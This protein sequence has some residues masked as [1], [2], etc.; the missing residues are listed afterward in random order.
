MHLIRHVLILLFCLATPAFADLKVVVSIKPIHSLVGA[1]MQNAGTPELLLDGTASPHDYA[2]RPS[3]ARRLQ[4]A[5]LVF[6]LGPELETFLTKPLKTLSAEKAH[7][8]LDTPDLVKLPLRDIEEAHDHAHA[9][10]GEHDPHVWLSPANA[11]ILTR[12]IAKI[13]SERDPAHATVYASNANK[14]MADLSLLDNELKQSLALLPKTSVVVFHDAYQYFEQAYG[15]TPATPLSM[16]PESPPGAKRLKALRQDLQCGKIKCIF[17]EPQFPTRLIETLTEGLSIKLE[18][19]DPLGANIN[20]GPDHYPQML[21]ALAASWK[22][23][24]S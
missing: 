4:N 9:E 8:L 24:T 23:C 19:L 18:T 3:D 13:L 10:H 15:L 7:A 5:D 17:S 22:R 6:W 21:R 12:A 16:N 11:S 2:L 14:L 20:P 1:V